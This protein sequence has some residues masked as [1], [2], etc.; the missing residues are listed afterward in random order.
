M[1]ILNA[2]TLRDPDRKVPFPI[3]NESTPDRLLT[4]GDFDIESVRDRRATA[5]CG[6]AR[7]SA[8]SSSTPTP[9]ARCSTRPVPTPGVCSPDNPLL[10]G[11]T[12]NLGGSNGFEAMAL[13]KDGRTLYPILEGPLVGDDPLDARRV[14]VRR[15]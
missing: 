4:G 6:S 2:I 15:R 13:S 8:R 14:R 9:P 3:V 5:R 10:L 12:P 1:T 7:S 11:R